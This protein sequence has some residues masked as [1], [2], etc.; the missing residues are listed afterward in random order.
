MI[1]QQK[2]QKQ[3]NDKNDKKNNKNNK[4]RETHFCLKL[5]YDSVVTINNI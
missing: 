5:K 3:K 1:K 2:Q 4:K